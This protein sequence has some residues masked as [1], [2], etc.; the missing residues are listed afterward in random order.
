[1]IEVEVTHAGRRLNVD[2]PA[3]D[4]IRS[5]VH[6]GPD[7]LIAE[8]PAARVYAKVVHGIVRLPVRGDEEL[9]NTTLDGGYTASSF[10]IARVDA[11]PYAPDV[12][13]AL[14]SHA[15]EESELQI[16][17][18]VGSP[19]V[20]DVHHVAGLKPLVTIDHGN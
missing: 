19:T 6:D 3:G 13:P 16:V 5:A 8:G 9:R 18:M 14:P 12:L 10:G 1:M 4:V 7:G 2:L 20:A 17:S 11:I 15:V